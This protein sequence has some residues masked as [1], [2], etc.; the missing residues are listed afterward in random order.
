MSAVISINL[1]TKAVTRAALCWTNLKKGWTW[2]EW[3]SN[4][5]STCRRGRTACFSWN[6]R[7]HP[8]TRDKV[9]TGWCKHESINLF[10][11]NHRN[12]P[13]LL[14]SIGRLSSVSSTSMN[15]KFTSHLTVSCILFRKKGFSQLPRE[16]KQT[17][18]ILITLIMK[19]GI[20]HHPSYLHFS[21][22]YAF[23]MWENCCFV[24]FFH[25]F[26]ATPARL[27]RWDCTEGKESY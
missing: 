7:I 18:E 8:R 3:A 27:S 2:P 11:K 4:E 12:M 22:A 25:T 10:A 26:S 1:I 9:K 14:K 23:K 24:F 13:N 5:P 17:M 15:A 19:A 20:S 21:L 6:G 16:N